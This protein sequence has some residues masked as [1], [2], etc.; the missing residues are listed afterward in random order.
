[1]TDPRQ[2]IMSSEQISLDTRFLSS[3]AERPKHDEKPN[4]ES[5]LKSY[6]TSEKRE[7]QTLSLDN[8]STKVGAL[9]QT[10]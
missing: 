6:R 10:E 2:L 7:V 3:G 8:L 1:M 4:S 5:N 9:V